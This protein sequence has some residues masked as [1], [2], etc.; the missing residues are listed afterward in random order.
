MCGLRL[1]ATIHAMVHKVECPLEV[2]FTSIDHPF[3][4][5]GSN[6]E[7]WQPPGSHRSHDVDRTVDAHR[8]A[9]CRSGVVLVGLVLP[10]LD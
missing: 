8:E 4:V 5:A 9:L 10:I 3:R 6:T 7:G 2:D 1:V